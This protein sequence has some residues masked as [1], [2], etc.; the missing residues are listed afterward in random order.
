MGPAGPPFRCALAGPTLVP[1]TGSWASLS[2]TRSRRRYFELRLK[3]AVKAAASKREVLSRLR[4]HRIAGTSLE[5]FLPSWHG[6]IASGQGNDLGYG[7]N[8][9]DWTIRSQAPKQIMLWEKVQRLS[10]GGVLLLCCVVTR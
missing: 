1:G 7:K 2:G 6:N 8:G 10:G 5:L 4:R 9:R 3:V